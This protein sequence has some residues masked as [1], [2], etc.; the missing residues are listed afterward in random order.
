MIEEGKTIKKWYEYIYKNLKRVWLSWVSLLNAAKR[1]LGFSV[2]LSMSR[3]QRSAVVKVWFPLPAALQ[4]P[5]PE[6]Y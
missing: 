6:T 5:Q 4:R 1:F 2:Y 3:P